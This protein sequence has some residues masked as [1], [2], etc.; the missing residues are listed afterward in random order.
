MDGGEEVAS[1]FVIAGGDTAEELEFGKEVFDQMACLVDFLVI[2]ALDF[3][4][5]F[6]WNHRDLARLL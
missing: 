1:S 2:F 3:A 4:V 6:G 5:G